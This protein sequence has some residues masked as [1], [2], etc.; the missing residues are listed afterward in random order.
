MENLIEGLQNEMTRCRE[1]LTMHEE[2][3]GGVVG[4]FGIA[5]IKQ[6]LAQAEKAIAEG[7]VVKELLAYEN[8]K[9]IEG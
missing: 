4:F 1:L 2:L 7:D 9:E 6:G 3:P 5:T 8:L